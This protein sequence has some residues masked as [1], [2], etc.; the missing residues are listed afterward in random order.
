L[1]VLLW[2]RLSCGFLSRYPEV[3]VGCCSWQPFEE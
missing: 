3:V 1:F 2:L